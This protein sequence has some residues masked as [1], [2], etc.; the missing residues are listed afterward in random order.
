MLIIYQIKLYEEFIS[1]YMPNIISVLALSQF[2]FK[3][4]NIH[5]FSSKPKLHL[6]CKLFVEEDLLIIFQF[7]IGV[8]PSSLRYQ[9]YLDRAV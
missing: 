4:F 2:P 3:Y 7:I 6:P 8:S 9:S 5:I 1:V